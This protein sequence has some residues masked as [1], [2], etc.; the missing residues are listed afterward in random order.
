MDAAHEAPAAPAAPPADE[1]TLRAVVL[2]AKRHPNPR[3]AQ[4]ALLQAT[5]D[6][7][8]C[9]AAA[10]ERRRA[11]G[12]TAEKLHVDLARSQFLLAQA[13]DRADI[14]AARITRIEPR[15]RPHYTPHARYRILQH[16]R[17][18]LL[19]V[20]ETAAAFLVTPQTVYNWIHETDDKPGSNAI[21]SSVAASPPVQR[22]A[23]AVGDLVR[24]MFAAGFGGKRKIAQNLLRNGWAVSTRT[25][26]RMI[27]AKPKPDPPPE[28]LTTVRG[29][30]PNHLWLLD[31]TSVPT[32]FPFL[33]LS[34]VTILDAC[35]RLPLASTL[36]LAVPSASLVISLLDHAIRTHGRPK[37]LVVD[38]GTQFTADAFKAYVESQSIKV[39]HGAVGQTHSLGLIDRFFRTAKDTLSLLSIRPWS[40]KDIEGRLHLGLLHY[41][42]VRPHTSLGALTPIEA[43]YGI[44]GHLPTPVSPPRGRPGDPQPEVPFDIAYL[45][46][47]IRAFPILVPKAA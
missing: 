4:R 9:A 34:L 20:D 43:Y 5:E 46:P 47:R 27:H 21:G 30:H 6:L 37:H 32:L 28:R 42:Y 31:I 7:T 25:V 45:D 29:D 35:S 1:L 33:K 23:T 19:S 44:R 14:L 18:Y 41:S 40:R 16:M 39:R 10:W 15:H 17:R 12:I 38:K 13:N 26:G 22:F 36:R 8:L 2:S 11:E 24:Q 3:Q